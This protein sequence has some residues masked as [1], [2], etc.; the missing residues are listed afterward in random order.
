MN[1]ESDSKF[2][3]RKWNIAIDQ[4]NANYKIGNEIIYSTEVLKSNLCDGRDGYILVRSDFTIIGHQATQVAFKK[5]ATFTK[6]ITKNDGT[7]I[8]LAE[9]L[10]LVRKFVVSFKR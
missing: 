4:S 2:L 9:D 10:D 7:T 6:A 3:T 1:E 5:S 8:D